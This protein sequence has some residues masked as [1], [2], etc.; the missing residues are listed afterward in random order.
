LR[1]VV[2][3]LVVAVPLASANRPVPPVIVISTVV[4]WGAGGGRSVLRSKVPVSLSPF[5]ATQV[6][7]PLPA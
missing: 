2:P 3:L 1:P 4:V 6:M 5:A 7:T